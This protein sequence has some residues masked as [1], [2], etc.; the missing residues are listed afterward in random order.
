[1]VLPHPGGLGQALSPT[2][3]NMGARNVGPQAMSRLQWPGVAAVVRLRGGRGPSIQNN[4]GD[5]HRP[6]GSPGGRLTLR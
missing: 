4:S 1:V 2:R 5:P 3:Q 6:T